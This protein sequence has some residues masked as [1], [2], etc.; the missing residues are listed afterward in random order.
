MR[1][2][3]VDAQGGVGVAVVEVD[4]GVEAV[5]LGGLAV[6]QAPR[7]EVDGKPVTVGAHPLGAGAGG[8]GELPA[9]LQPLP[10]EERSKHPRAVA[11][12]LRDASVGVA[13]VHEP[14]RTLCLLAHL[15]LVGGFRGDD[16]DHAV[17]TDSGPAISQRPCPGS[18]QPQSA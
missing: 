12:H 6:A 9:G 14:G 8:D 10:A 1:V 2:P 15:W 16:T 7:P 13:V 3:E 5:A 18:R 17:T 11:T 4:Q